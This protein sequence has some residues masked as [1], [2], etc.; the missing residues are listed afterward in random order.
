MDMYRGSF[1]YPGERQAE[2]HS[3]ITFDEW[4]CTSGV[5]ADGQQSPGQ[6]TPSES[7]S[8]VRTFVP[9]DFDGV[10]PL[11]PGLFKKN[12]ANRGGFQPVVPL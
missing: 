3:F 6:L 9:R 11:G 1:V 7:E 8:R 5:T 12:L 10:F 4:T 2:Y